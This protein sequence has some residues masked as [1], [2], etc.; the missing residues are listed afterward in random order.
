MSKI[1]DTF[2]TAKE[3]FIA[4]TNAYADAA[5]ELMQECGTD[6]GMAASELVKVM[7]ADYPVES[8]RDN[9]VLKTALNRCQ[10][11]IKRAG[12]GLAD[13]IGGRMVF[14]FST[15]TDNGE[16]VRTVSAEYLT[17]SQ[18]DTIAE[19]AA[20]DE[21][22]KAERDAEDKAAAAENERIQKMQLTALDVFLRIK[23]DIASTYPDHDIREILAAGLAWCDSQDSDVIDDSQLSDVA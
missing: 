16:K 18:L 17:Q 19:R 21:A 11:A 9:P 15:A 20:Q 12:E 1:V 7:N 2:H 13:G 14:K 4:G 10:R 5:S 22:I 23:S 8:C 3:S 6:A